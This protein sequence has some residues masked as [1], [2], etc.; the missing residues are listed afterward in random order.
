MV[1]VRGT[2]NPESA[3]LSSSR[4]PLL[5][6]AVT[7]GW[8]PELARKK[9]ASTWIRPAQIPNDKSHL[10]H[11]AYQDPSIPRAPCTELSAVVVR[12]SPSTANSG[13]DCDTS[14][15]P[16][17]TAH[18]RRFTTDHHARGHHPRGDIHVRR[19]PPHRLPAGHL[20]HSGLH[21]HPRVRQA[22]A[23]QLR[24]PRRQRRD[25]HRRGRNPPGPRPQLGQ[26]QGGRPEARAAL[27]GQRQVQ[28]RQQ[29]LK[30]G[31]RALR[32]GHRRGVQADPRRQDRPGHDKG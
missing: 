19:R 11:C 20:Q 10:Q 32:R 26:W 4:G 28:G 15:S 27:H 30:G 23:R 31:L 25:R 1:L 6:A 5:I 21:P 16:I 7:Q 18:P 13:L 24:G 3:I 8:G 14:P 29:G 17:S 12:P 2:S 9:G 22:I